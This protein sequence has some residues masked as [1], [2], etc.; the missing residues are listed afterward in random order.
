M[1]WFRRRF[2]SRADLDREIQFHL[3]EETRLRTERGASPE[4]AR[5]EARHAF[6]NAMRVR[7]DVDTLNPIGTAEEIWRDLRYGAR[8]LRRDP[9]FAAVAILSLALGIGANTSIFQLLDAVRL[10]T[11]PVM[12]PS[13][14]AEVRIANDANDS[15]G[16]NFTGGRPDLTNAL[17]EQIRGTQQGFS[18]IAAWGSASLEMATGGESRRARGLWVSGDYFT[19][20]GVTPILGRVISKEDDT[21]GCASPGVVLSY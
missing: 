18:G 20:L 1:R 7:E 16:G 14:L 8:L 9:G 15:R 10:R 13:R 19:T 12:D 11:L 3:A 6:G 21:P 5:R 4:S 2:E 17:W